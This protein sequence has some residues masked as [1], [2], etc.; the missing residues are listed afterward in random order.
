MSLTVSSFLI[1]LAFAVKKKDADAALAMI[2]GFDPHAIEFYC[3]QLLETKK[4]GALQ[5]P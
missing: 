2:G 4:L 1:L 3:I 5:V